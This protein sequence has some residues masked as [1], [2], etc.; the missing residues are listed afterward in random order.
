MADDAQ[1]QTRTSFVPPWAFA[2]LLPWFA[3]ALLSNLSRAGAGGDLTLATISGTLI[4]VLLLGIGLPYLVYRIAKRSQKAGIYAMIA[5]GVL[6]TLGQGVPMVLP[7]GGGGLAVVRSPEI[8]RLIENGESLRVGEFQDA[9]ER[10]IQQTESGLSGDALAQTMALH[11]A[12]SGYWVI[13]NE[14]NKAATAG[15]PLAAKLTSGRELSRTDMEELRRDWS[16]FENAVFRCDQI[17]KLLDQE[18]ERAERSLSRDGYRDGRAA[19][20]ARRIGGATRRGVR[21]D[22]AEADRDRWTA[23]MGIAG[24]Y[25]PPAQR[26]AGRLQDE[27]GRWLDPSEEREARLKQLADANERVAAALKQLQDG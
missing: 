10:E 16:H 3:L 7:A 12:M 17:I 21:R 24:T 23:F 25:W 18:Q 19:S 2:I 1:Q 4:G 27:D 13:S 11:S 9:L 14:L 5:V 8:A 15:A 6:G 22:L 20:V 26:K